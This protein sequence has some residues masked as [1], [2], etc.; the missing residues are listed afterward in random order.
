MNRRLH[1]REAFMTLN[2]FSS[3]TPAFVVAAW[4]ELRHCSLLSASLSSDRR[5]WRQWSLRSFVKPGYEGCSQ[6]PHTRH[7]VC[8]DVLP[9]IFLWFY[10]CRETQALTSQEN[11]SFTC[12]E[13]QIVSKGCRSVNKSLSAYTYPKKPQK[14]GLLMKTFCVFQTSL[15]VYIYLGYLSIYLS[16]I[17]RSM[18]FTCINI[19]IYTNII[20]IY[21]QIF[22]AYIYG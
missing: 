9:L 19:Y 16:I 21:V 10:G 17:Y 5:L 12:I 3:T 7:W 14:C 8:P 15:K 2:M 1:P 18:G 4:N 13:S 20:Y 6:F 11:T 22:Y